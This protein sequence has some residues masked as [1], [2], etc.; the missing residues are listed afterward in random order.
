[1]QYSCS[2]ACRFICK[3][4]CHNLVIDVVIV[5]V[6]ADVLS[7]VITVFTATMFA[8]KLNALLHP[9]LFWLDLPR[10]GP[11]IAEWRN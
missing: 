1:M 9:F 6:G 8:S 7:T 10:P 5:A 4:C 3:W 2:F 11:G